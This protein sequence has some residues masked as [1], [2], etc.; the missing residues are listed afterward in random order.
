MK[1]FEFIMLFLG[2]LFQILDLGLAYGFF[3]VNFRNKLFHFM[4][5]VK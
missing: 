1:H 5:F 3:I 2:L 4:K